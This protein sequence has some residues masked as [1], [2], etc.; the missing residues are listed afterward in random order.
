MFGFLLKKHYPVAYLLRALVF[1]GLL[2]TVVGFAIFVVVDYQ[3]ERQR[4]LEDNTERAIVLSQTIDNYLLR[5][6]ALARSFAGS[7]EILAGNL[8]PAPSAHQVLAAMY[9][10]TGSRPTA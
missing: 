1:A 2:P 5:A 3:N 10:C 7:D 6:Q 4:L 8:K 9:W